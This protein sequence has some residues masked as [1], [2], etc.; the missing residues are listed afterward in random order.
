MT[1]KA[2]RWYWV[3]LFVWLILSAPDTVQGVRS[4]ASV[5]DWVTFAVWAFALVGSVTFAVVIWRGRGN[6]PAPER[7][8]PATV[9]VEDVRDA[10]ASAPSAVRAV[11][12][13]RELHPG[14]GLLDAKNLVDAHARPH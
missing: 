7:V 8:D 13:L 4:D 6:G 3:L 10:V 9:P 14:L 11:K 12:A 2:E 5:W 1:R